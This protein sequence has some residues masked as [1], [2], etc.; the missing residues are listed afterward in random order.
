MVCITLFLFLIIILNI[1][2]IRKEA[3]INRKFILKYRMDKANS[4]IE[5][6][7]RMAKALGISYEVYMKYKY[8]HFNM[9]GHSNCKCKG[10]EYRNWNNNRYES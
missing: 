7:E 1:I 3:F 10:I 2:R 5:E 8:Y 9:Y 6:D 4:P